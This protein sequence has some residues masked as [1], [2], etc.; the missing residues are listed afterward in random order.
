MI[1]DQPNLRISREHDCSLLIGWPHTVYREQDERRSHVGMGSALAYY[2]RQNI[3]NWPQHVAKALRASHSAIKLCP[4]IGASTLVSPFGSGD[5]L[6]GAIG[7]E[8][9][10]PLAPDRPTPNVRSLRLSVQHPFG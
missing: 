7:R 3:A 6:T 2:L 1:R 10:L 8:T 4:C 5:H 9:S